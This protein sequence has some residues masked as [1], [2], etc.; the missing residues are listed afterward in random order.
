MAALFGRRIDICEMG[1]DICVGIKAVHDIEHLRVF[2]GLDGK[3]RSAAAADHQDIDL[4]LHICCRVLGK[5]RHACS[6]D[7]D[8]GGITACENSRQL[9]IFVLHDRALHALCQIAVTE[10]TDFD[11]HSCFLLTAIARYNE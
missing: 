7:A 10:D 11:T 3:I 8:R 4:V 6:A 9:Q 2:G 5:D 1:R